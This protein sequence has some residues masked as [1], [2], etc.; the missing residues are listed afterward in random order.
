MRHREEDMKLQITQLSEKEAG[1]VRKESDLSE[2][3][4]KLKGELNSVTY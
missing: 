3:V 4:K 2:V 1:S